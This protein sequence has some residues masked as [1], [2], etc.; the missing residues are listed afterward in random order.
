MDLRKVSTLAAPGLPSITGLAGVIFGLLVIVDCARFQQKSGECTTAFNSGA[1]AIG[2]GLSGIAGSIASFVTKN[3]WLRDNTDEILA[4]LSKP[5]KEHNIA[6]PPVIPAFPLKQYDLTEL[7]KA[8]IISTVLSEKG[9]QLSSKLNRAELIELGSK[10]LNPG[11]ES[12]QAGPIR[13]A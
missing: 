1:V 4:L 9:I 2:L 10:L 3:P 6:E 13:Q 5:E 8:E 11:L 12:L 7:S